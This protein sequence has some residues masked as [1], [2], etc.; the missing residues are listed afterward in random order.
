MDDKVE[1][2]GIGFVGLLTLIMVAAKAFGFAQYSWMV[3]FLPLVA[4]IV[5]WLAIILIVIIAGLIVEHRE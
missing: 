5:L 4:S 2:T 1:H 3:A